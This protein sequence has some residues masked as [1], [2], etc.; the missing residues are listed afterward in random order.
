MKKLSLILLFTIGLLTTSCSNDDNNGGDT[1][2]PLVGKWNVSKVGTIVAGQEILTDAPQNESGCNKDYIQ[3]ESDN[4]VTAGD[5]SSDVSP[6]ALTTQSGTY[7]RT[8]NQLT[9]VIDGTNRTET[10]L[11]L[12]ASELKVKDET[13]A[14]VL[15]TRG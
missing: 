7:S 1:T 15:F 14:I 3:F 4:T 6:C 5:Y 2:I 12:T 9:T 10:I 11:N 13:G 8:G